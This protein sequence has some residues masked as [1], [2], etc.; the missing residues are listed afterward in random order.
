MAWIALAVT[1]S[2]APKF[3]VVRVTDIYRGLPSTAA[4]QKKMQVQREAI[5]S[6]TRAERF[7]ASLTEME[8]LESQLRAVKDELDSENGK[9]LVR[10]YEIK[11]QEAETLRQA[12]EEY[13]AAEDK[14]IN[15][16]MVAA[17]RE[18]LGRISVAARQIATERNLEGVFDTSGNSNTGVPFVLYAANAE[19]VIAFLGE[20]P[21]VEAE[22]VPDATEVEVEGS[23]GAAPATE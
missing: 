3:G 20:K 12:F 4:M 13:R 2:A 8:S 14:R 18:S 15:T 7:R 21:V 16:E 1:L 19:D 9:K 17:T 10:A 23:P 5:L 6:N 11:R 22:A